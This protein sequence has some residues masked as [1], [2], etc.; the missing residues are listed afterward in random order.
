MAALNPRRARTLIAGLIAAGAVFT[1]LVL[2]LDEDGR[3]GFPAGLRLPAETAGGA[4]WSPDG[5]WIAIPNRGGVLLWAA[6]RSS[7]RQLRAPRMPRYL[8]S[9]PGRIG[10]SRD[11]T[12]LRYVTMIGPAKNKGSWVTEVPTGGGAVRQRSLGANV[13]SA[14]WGPRGWP[15]VYAPAPGGGIWSLASFGGKPEK[16]LDRPGHEDNPRISPDGKRILFTVTPHEEPD[17]LWIARADGS[18]ARRLGGRFSFLHFSWAPDSRRI[19]VIG[20]GA[21][22]N[23]ASWL[24]VV[25]AR[26]GTRRPVRFTGGAIWHPAWTPGGRWITYA[27]NDGR[28]QKAR[29]RGGEVVEL[30]HFPGELVSNLLWSPNGKK[31]AFSSVEVPEERP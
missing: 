5:R 1:A 14:D 17:A 20:A 29:P 11:G 26:A 7:V 13:G 22:T 15:L 24:Y 31:L 30:A 27:L 9:I 10:W 16:L 23:G 2:A 6:D 4:S 3:P 18:A 25:A 21:R 19:A 8:N 28:I 12:R